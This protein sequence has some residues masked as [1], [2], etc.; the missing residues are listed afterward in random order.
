MKRVLF[1]CTGNYYRSRFAEILFNHLAKERGL[2]WKAQ[3][4]ALAIERGKGNVGP[5]A[6][7]AVAGLR[8][9]EVIVDE[10]ARFPMAVC[11]EDW[12]GC[13]IVVAV[14][15]KEHL[16]LVEERWPAWVQRTEFWN[17]EDVG[18]AEPEDAMVELDREVRVMIEWL[19]KDNGQA[20]RR[21]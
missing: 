20:S 2:A 15:R 13:D 16:V 14:D 4:R 3:S 11:E 17:V 19:S 9:R 8:K 6:Q 10:G 5:I 12:R 1:L 18:F 21:R 7:W